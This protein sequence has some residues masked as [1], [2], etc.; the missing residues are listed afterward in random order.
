M[1]GPK[2]ILEVQ[3]D[4]QLTCAR[5]SPCGRVLAGGG[6]D[7]RLHRWAFNEKLEPMAAVDGH[8]G[9]V[10]ALAFHPEHRLLFTADSWGRLR[11]QGYEGEK[12]R[13]HW[14]L[15]AAHDGWI[16]SLDVS[17]VHVASAG[18]DRAVRV[19]TCSGEKVA[20]WKGEEEI[21]AVAFHPDGKHLVFGDLK[22]MILAWDFAAGRIVREFD[23]A[24]FYKYD[25]IQ[26][27]DGLRRLLFVDGGRTLA[28]AGSAPTKGATMQGIPTLRVFDYETGA[29]KGEFRHGAPKDGHIDDLAYHPDGYYMAVTTGVPGNGHFFCVRPGEA[30]P[31]FDHTKIPNLHCVALHPGGRRVVVTGTNRG[32]N[33]NGRKLNKAGEY[34][35]NHTPL[36]LFELPGA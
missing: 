22:G 25:R 35:G 30:K 9:W 31:F 6:M 33:G 10:S 26:D 19:W 16:R 32:S 21:Y 5:F 7:G 17:A 1:N 11:G 28:A 8:H 13:T 34:E 18:R 12:P 14:D 15:G 36:H 27:V 3:S 2:P 29:P 23:G 4:P 20:E 24:V